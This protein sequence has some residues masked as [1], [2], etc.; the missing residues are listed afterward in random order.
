MYK[1]NMRLQIINSIHYTRVTT[2]FHPNRS[3]FLNIFTLLLNCNE[4][5]IFTWCILASL[6]SL[7][8]YTI[9]SIIQTLSHFLKPN[10]LLLLVQGLNIKNLDKITAFKNSESLTFYA[11]LTLLGPRIMTVIHKLLPHHQARYSKIT[12]IQSLQGR[13]F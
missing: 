1:M 9:A 2:R 12:L 10:P 13:K 5:P 7:T 4:T 3:L 8:C 6:V 11:C